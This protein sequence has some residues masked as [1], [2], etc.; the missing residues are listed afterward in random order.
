MSG[1]DEPIE[2]AAPIVY[3]AIFRLAFDAIEAGED[4]G[5][6]GR[7][8]PPSVEDYARL[9]GWDRDPELVELMGRAVEDAEEGR[10][11]SY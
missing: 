6:L 7:R 1:D 5:R 9:R 4:L 2:R 11:P 10:Q 3:R 8:L